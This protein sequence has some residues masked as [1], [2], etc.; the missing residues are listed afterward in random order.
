VIQKLEINNTHFVRNTQDFWPK[1]N[2]SDDKKKWPKGP[3]FLPICL[4][5]SS[6]MWHG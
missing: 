1:R 2:R 5:W 3:N 4:N 6:Q